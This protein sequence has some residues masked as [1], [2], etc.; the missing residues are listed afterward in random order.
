MRRLLPDVADEPLDQAYDDLRL[1]GPVE[2]R[3]GVSLGMVASADGAATVAGRTAS[4]GGAADQAAYVALRAAADAILVGA[5][6]VRAEN[7][8]PAAGGA[9]RQR[10]RM[11]KGLTPAPRLVVVSN[12]LDFDP[13]ARVFGDPDHPPLIATNARAAAQASSLTGIAELMVVGDEAVDL[14]V[15]LVELAQRSYGGVLCEGGP[16]LNGALLEHD[17]VDALF[18][19]VAPVLVG[20]AAGR[21]VSGLAEVDLPLELVELRSNEGELLLHYRRRTAVLDD[22]L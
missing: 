6:T 9:D 14:T 16:T 17:L 3:A 15:L 10:R 12:R 18:L 7:Y 19:T 11:S 21:I 22:R 5:G 1:T 13:A 4:L 8:G 2:G 20:G